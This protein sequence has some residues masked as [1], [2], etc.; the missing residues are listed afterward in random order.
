[1]KLSAA[2]TN[3][4][5]KAFVDTEELSITVHK[6][7]NRICAF[8]FRDKKRKEEKRFEVKNFKIVAAWETGQKWLEGLK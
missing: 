8:T 1:M 7:S 5:A 6:S 3:H 4:I 2:R